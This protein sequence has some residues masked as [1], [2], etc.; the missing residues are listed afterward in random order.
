M[1]QVLMRAL[2]CTTMIVAP[3]AAALAQSAPTPPPWYSLDGNGVDLVTGSFKLSRTDLTIGPDAGG[4]SYVEEDASLFGQRN[5]LT[6]TANLDF[7]NGVVSVILGDTTDIFY[8]VGKTG[9]K[10]GLGRGSQFA[11]NAGSYIYTAADGTTIHFTTYGGSQSGTATVADR[12]VSPT[13]V[14]TTYAWKSFVYK[15]IGPCGGQNDPC[16]LF[17]ALRLQGVSTNRGYG[18]KL[19]YAY[20]GTVDETNINQWNNKVALTAVNTAKIACDVTQDASCSA[21]PGTRT[22]RYGLEGASTITVTDPL[23]QIARYTFDASSRVTNIRLPASGERSCRHLRRR[24]SRSVH[25]PTARQVEL[26]LCD[27]RH[28][29]DHNGP[30]SD[31]Q[32]ADRGVGFDQA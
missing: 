31:G 7:N 22:V 20:S 15:S 19:D 5:S 4:L 16:Q 11:G 27:E 25:R 18:M 26:H 13:G 9:Y 32:V 21:L 8:I 24:W 29:A 14:V 12:V 23:N 28:A 10:S 1:K 2:L 6:I 3:G 17:L 30:G